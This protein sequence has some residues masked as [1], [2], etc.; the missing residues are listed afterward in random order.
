MLNNVLPLWTLPLCEE[1]SQ[2][3]KMQLQAGA[4]I[5]LLPLAALISGAL[6]ELH[7]RLWQ[8]GMGAELPALQGCCCLFHA[9]ISELHHTSSLQQEGTGVWSGIFPSVQ[10][11]FCLLWA[12]LLNSHCWVCRIP[13]VSLVRA[14]SRETLKIKKKKKINS[15]RWHENV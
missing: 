15:I 12:Q 11:Q 9:H 2:V 3:L 13:A 10:P 5:P 8:S 14:L 1:H 4:E 6:P 7:F